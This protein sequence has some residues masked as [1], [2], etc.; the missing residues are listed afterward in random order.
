MRSVA[1]GNWG[2]RK[3]RF[4]LITITFV[5]SNLLMVDLLWLYRFAV[6]NDVEHP[7]SRCVSLMIGPPWERLRDQIVRDATSAASSPLLAYE[8][9]ELA[10]II[11]S[12]AFLAG[13]LVLCCRAIGP[14]R[15][16]CRLNTAIVAVAIL[17]VETRAICEIWRCWD[18]RYQRGA[19]DTLQSWVWGEES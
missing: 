2:M 18:F 9:R 16:S 3:S 12:A 19:T 8:R 11:V 1:R 17:A 4:F 5:L 13:G 7:D 6:V 15:W 14:F 10:T